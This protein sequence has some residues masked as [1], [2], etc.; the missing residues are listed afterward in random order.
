MFPQC[1]AR[2]AAA[3]WPARRAHRRRFATCSARATV[4]SVWANKGGG[5]GLLAVPLLS[6]ANAFVLDYFQSLCCGAFVQLSA[7]TGVTIAPSSRSVPEPATLALFAIGFALAG[8]TARCK[9][10]MPA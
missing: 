2:P 9:R 4:N 8:F 1:R 10:E 6:G 5:P 7:G 3:A